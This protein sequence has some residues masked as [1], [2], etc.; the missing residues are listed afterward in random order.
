MSRVVVLALVLT[1]C[2]GTAAHDVTPHSP[3]TSDIDDGLLRD[4]PGTNIVV[5]G[6]RFDQRHSLVHSAARRVIEEAAKEVGMQDL[7][8]AWIDCTDGRDVHAVVG[9]AFDHSPVVRTVIRG[10]RL[11][12]LAACATRAGWRTRLDTDGRYL[13]VARTVT[14][15]GLSGTGDFVLGYLALQDGA[16][17]A[18]YRTAARASRRDLEREGA[19]DTTKIAASDRHLLELARRASRTSALW[20][21]ANGAGTK[22]G[23]QMGD[24]I[25]S[26]DLD[27][28]GGI[29]FDVTVEVPDLELRGD[30]LREYARTWRHVATDPGESAL[31]AGVRFRQEGEQLAFSLRWNSSQLGVLAAQV[32][33]KKE[34][35][36]SGNGRAAEIDEAISK[37]NEFT[38]E[39]CAC[40]DAACAQH[41]SDEMTAWGRT[42]AAK[43]DVGQGRWSP[44]QQREMADVTTRL[45]ECMTRAMS[46][47][48]P[49]P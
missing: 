48:A 33:P 6:A 12:D 38:G 29:H 40:P 45:T 18:S 41:V 17:Y 15:P 23:G 31:V 3:A 2:G 13:E 36:M 32:A 19:A 27:G 49:G 7:V 37:M 1:A 10:V 25:G 42:E 26:G 4:L 24:V 5:I 34:R 9:V 14:A 43:P 30:I 8:H 39:M 44:D 47:T 11:S 46:G 21:V 16:V 28:D 20:L 22:R 35:F